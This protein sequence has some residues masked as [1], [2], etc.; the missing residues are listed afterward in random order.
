MMAYGG[1]CLFLYTKDGYDIVLLHWYIDVSGYLE[2]FYFINM[3]LTHDC[4]SMMNG[5]CSR[6][7]TQGLGG[8]NMYDYLMLFQSI[9]SGS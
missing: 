6:G 1:I 3:I 2:D 4:P 8:P 9:V 7:F 5:S